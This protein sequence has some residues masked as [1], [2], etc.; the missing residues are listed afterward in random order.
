MK[1][2]GIRDQDHILGLGLCPSEDIDKS[3]EEQIVVRGSHLKS[4]K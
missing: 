4:H 2:V 3:E 1:G